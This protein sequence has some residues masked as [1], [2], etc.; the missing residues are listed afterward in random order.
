V[1]KSLIS[2]ILQLGAYRSAETSR[3]CISQAIPAHG[4]IL[5][6]HCKLRKEKLAL[7][8]GM[9]VAAGAVHA[10]Y[11]PIFDLSDLHGSSGMVLNGQAT[12][13]EAGR[14]ISAA[15]DINGDG[16][17]DLIIGAPYN[18]SGAAFAGAS[19]IVFGTDQG[20]PATLELASLDGDNG[21]VINGVA[22]FDFSGFSVSGAGD[23]NGDEIEDVI[24][25]APVAS[26]DANESG[27]SYLVYGSDLGLPSPLSLASINGSN[28][29]VI[30][31]VGAYSNSGAAVS[32]AGDIDGDGFDDLVIGAP[33]DF[34]GAGASYVIFG[35]D[36]G[37]SSPF[38]LSGVNG[39]NGFRIDGVSAGDSSGAAVSAAGDVNGD[40]LDDLVIGAPLA[41]PSGSNAGAAYVVFGDLAGFPNPLSLS[42]LD[43]S[44]GFAINGEILSDMV[45]TSV[46]AAGDVNGDGFDDLILG[47]S[48]ANPNGDN[49]GASYV[50]FGS[51]ESLPHPLNLS[52]LDGDNGFVITGVAANDES[53]TSVASAGDINKDGIDDLIVGAP[54]AF[55]GGT[56]TG[57][58]YVI[59]GSDL[60]WSAV[61]N[62]SSLNGTNGFRLDGV[63]AGD[64]AGRSVSAAG[65]INADGQED[66]VIGA[67]SADPNGERSGTAYVVF[68]LLKANDDVI[69]ADSFEQ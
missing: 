5:I 15:G 66:F 45:G 7:A 44:N 47:A 59:F 63:N 10:D 34:G 48:E 26:P 46:S 31:G 41:G 37:P 3:V 20:L 28:G 61:F 11:P 32:A 33:Y 35:S 55:S 9:A 22:I 4:G 57:S 12:E 60:G 68:D 62:L 24:I 39:V 23:I 25:G 27:S 1:R 42:G 53:G 6:I 17:D 36:S 51:G 58:G 64:L 8:I 69:F 49:S 67:P 54:I 13:D 50:V 52:D 38:N 19:Y 56:S 18:N 29:V 43:G 21:I 16:F 40:G 65:D 2:A 14:S 30:N